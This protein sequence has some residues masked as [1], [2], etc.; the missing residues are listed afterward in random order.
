[1]HFSPQCKQHFS[2][3]GQVS[4]FRHLGLSILEHCV[5][6]CGQEP[7]LTLWDRIRHNLEILDYSLRQISGIL[8]TLKKGNSRVKEAGYQLSMAGHLRNVKKSCHLW[9]IKSDRFPAC[10]STM[11]GFGLSNP[12]VPGVEKVGEITQLLCFIN[13]RN[14][15]PYKGV[16]CLRPHRN[17]VEKFKSPGKPLT[18]STITMLY[19][20]TVAISGT[21]PCFLSISFRSWRVCFIFIAF[22]Y[23]SSPQHTLQ[24]VNMLYEPWSSVRT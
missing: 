1:M 19:L 20:K 7:V 6:F 22:G 14:W 11:N 24:G 18:P 2:A 15:G 10:P 16:S 4:S 9:F 8:G 23:Q 5:G 3:N 21:G 12:R 13:R 17:P